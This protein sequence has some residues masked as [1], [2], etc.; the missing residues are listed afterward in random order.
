[1]Q[2]FLL[3]LISVSIILNG[4]I[5][6]I[7]FWISWISFFMLLISV[8]ISLRIKALELGVRKFLSTTIL[9]SGLV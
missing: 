6:F 8:I 3:V 1:M 5:G 4:D 7:L 9:L 2:F